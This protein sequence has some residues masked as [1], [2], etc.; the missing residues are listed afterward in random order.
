MQ[1]HR[2]SRNGQ[3][4]LVRETF[5]RTPFYMLR[6]KMYFFLS[7]NFFADFLCE[8]YLSM[9]SKSSTSNLFMALVYN[10]YFAQHHIVIP[11]HFVTA[12]T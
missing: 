7:P 8:L 5:P 10:W 3:T 11:D 6:L 4:V 12:K 1:T 2:H 9:K